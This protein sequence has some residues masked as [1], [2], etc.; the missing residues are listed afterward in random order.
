[1]EK[2][3]KIIVA[4][5]I[6]VSVIIVIG[7]V[8]LVWYKT[9]RRVIASANM[10]EGITANNIEIDTD[11]MKETNEGVRNFCANFFNETVTEYDDNVFVSPLS[12]MLAL[13]MIGNA[14]KNDTLTQMEDAFGMNISD[15][16]N[17]ALGYL[18]SCDEYNTV[19]SYNSLWI[20]E[21]CADNVNKDF[22]QLN[23]DYYRA[24]VYKTSFPDPAV[25]DINLWVNKSTNGLIKKL[26][27]LDG[28]VSE[29]TSM[30]II[31]SIMFESEWEEQYS[32]DDNVS[33]DFINENGQ[34][35]RVE[36]MHSTEQSYIKTGDAHGFCKN[37]SDNR[38]MFVALLPDEDVSISQFMDSFTGGRIKNIIDNVTNE[39]VEAYLPKFTFDNDLDII[40]VLK[41][42]GITDVFEAGKAELNAIGDSNYVHYIRQQTYISVDE[43][44]TSAAAVTYALVDGAGPRR[45]IL[46]RPFVFMIYDK[47]YDIPVFIGVVRNL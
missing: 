41:N 39:E 26:E 10:M 17:F 31:N 28:L 7:V 46:N 12:A 19:S 21:K 22:L 15:M 25:H 11:K 40:N 16:N 32:K 45:L 27:S 13:G 34:N 35:E 37:Y 3:K 20:N 9:K 29:D 1:M 8:L 44:K 33:D 38:H 23:A 43:K 2:K 47:K 24:D 42:L 5:V 6:F 4:A 36:Y 18:K 14:A 30:A